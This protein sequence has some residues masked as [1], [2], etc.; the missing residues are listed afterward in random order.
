[1]LRTRPRA[2]PSRKPGKPTPHSLNRAEFITGVLAGKSMKTN[3]TGHAA[4]TGALFE[5][6]PRMRSTPIK[7]LLCTVQYWL[8]LV[9]FMP[10]ECL[11]AL[12]NMKW[13]F[14]HFVVLQ[15]I[16]GKSVNYNCYSS[17]AF[18]MQM[19]PR[20]TTQYLFFRPLNTDTKHRTQIGKARKV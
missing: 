14:L 6:C 11:L 1:M 8:T 17:S 16:I 5:L 4:W 10:W 19:C 15:M 13:L 7:C 3:K 12:G 18:E 2:G 9:G 20:A